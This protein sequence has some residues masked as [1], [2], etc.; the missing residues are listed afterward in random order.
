M[1]YS[2]WY[3]PRQFL[4]STK[5][6]KIILQRH[7]KGDDTLWTLKSSNITMDRWTH[8]AVTWKHVT[9]SVLIYADGKIKGERLYP[10]GDTFSPPTG[11]QYLIGRD[12]HLNSHHFYGLLMD[13]YVFGTALS[14][15][16]ITKLRGRLYD[17]I[18]KN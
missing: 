10:P 4:L 14:Q 11:W 8:V 9:G 16:Q 7:Q 1:I 17:S 18:N 12:V 5:N 13:L 2:D 6:H 3:N 15:E